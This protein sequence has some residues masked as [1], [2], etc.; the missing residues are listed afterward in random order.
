MRVV[1]ALLAGMC[2]W[3]S[4]A[5]RADVVLLGEQHIGD[6][7][8]DGFTPS[9]PVTRT[10]MLSSPSHFHL[11]QGTTIT[12]VR[13]DSAVY[14]V[15]NVARISIDGAAR[16]GS[17]SLLTNVFTF[18]SPVTLTSGVHTIAP[19]PGCLS[20]L[21]VV[22]CPG[23]TGNDLGFGSL[24]LISAQT[25]TSRALTRRR[26]IG[27]DNDGVN[28]N[29]GGQYY[30]DN[31]DAPPDDLRADM[32]FSVDVSRLLS[33]VEVY[34]LRGV[35]TA[36]GD[37]AQVL[38]DGARIGE[39]TSSGDPLQIPTAI[40]LA[41]G[42]HT[43]S[44]L[45]GS[46]GSGN[47][48]SI[49][50]DDVILRFGAPIGGIPGR[51]NAVDIGG[52]AV[53]GV[54]QTKV[55]G[56][57]I[58]L[59]AYAL[60]LSAS[61]VQT[62]YTGTV[63]VE[64]LDAGDDSGATDTW[65]CRSSWTS[66]QSLG[67]LTYAAADNGR[68]TLSFTYGDALKVARIRIYDPDTGISGCSADTFAIRPGNFL[69]EAWHATSVTAGIGTR[70]DNIG[71]AGTPT[72]RAGQPFTVLATARTSGGATAG[73]YTANPSVSV[74]ST[75]E[76]TQPGT[77][78][79]GN[80]RG[81]GSGRRRT[82]TARYTEAGTFTLRV[83]DATFADADSADS[84]LAQREI[85]GTVGVGRFTPDHFSLVSRNTPVFAPACGR[86]GYLGQSFDYATAP[87]AVIEAVNAVGGRT[88]NY[89]GQLYKLPSTLG[90]GTYRAVNA[91]TGVAVTLDSILVPTPDHGLASRGAGTAE[92]TYVTN[93]GIAALRSLPV[94]PFDLEIELEA[95]AIEDA[96]GIVYAD[97]VA[98]P[99]KFGAAG[100]GNGIAF[101]GG[102][103]QQRFGRLFLLNGYG[104]ERLPLD[105]AYGTE[106][107]ASATSG[108]GRNLADACSVGGA[109]TLSAGISA[110]TTVVGSPS[111]LLAGQGTIRLAV[112]GVT[113]TLTVTLD[114]VSWLRSD[115]NGDGSY[116][117]PVS[118]QAAFGQFRQG[119]K[120]IY[121]RE[122]YR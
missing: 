34:R 73:S 113:G 32:T 36:A 53:T 78:S 79:E 24:T 13:F 50:W 68:R 55:A 83:S 26:H 58:S 64:L 62:D 31:V 86:F 96:D 66:A 23:S 39:F 101:T 119:D 30:P 63:N 106:Y 120:Q 1:A 11:S 57:P 47:R 40:A 21:T 65:G 109:V 116:T 99:L 41:A 91:T 105:L 12:G 111:A 117:E 92:L 82:D 118:A 60:N 115:T 48:D 10:Q 8:S 74:Q 102:A 25:T 54:I 19:D 20:A 107:Y 121:L 75:I 3:A 122:T 28:D 70:L 37:H 17:F 90:A 59:H 5:A 6:D 56:L 103:K 14:Q 42:T 94:A 52:N 85:V 84:S 97:P 33:L 61:G 67:L 51:F 9:D 69:V 95:P 108:F 89:E 72:H 29:Y 77:L 4:A 87:E 114:G 27:D 104:S 16:T 38:V 98:T 71:V 35:N 80:W 93:A 49:S 45:A 18:G 100:A 44:I 22:A 7:E 88:L 15:A 112:P 43:L 2:L 46:L 76:G 110:S 81:D